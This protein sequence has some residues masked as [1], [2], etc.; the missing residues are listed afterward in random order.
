[1]QKPAGE[2]AP[3]PMRRSLIWSI[4]ERYLSA[5][6]ALAV[7]MIIARLLTP[8]QIGIFS[9]C[10]ATMLLASVLRDFGVTEYVLQERELTPAKLRSVMTVALATAWGVGALVFFSR[11][12]LAA[13]YDEPRLVAV[14]G[15]LS[16]NFLLLPF[17][18]PAFAMLSRQLRLRTVFAVQFATGVAGGLTSVALA[19]AGQ[20]ELSLAWGSVAGVATQLVL[21]LA[22]CRGQALTLPGAAHLREVL[23][24]GAYTM[25]SRALDVTSAN[26]HEFIIARHFGFTAV[27]LFSRAKGAVDLFQTNV[28]SA[29][30]RVASPTMAAAHRSDQSIVQM[31]AQGTANYTAL[32]WPAYL[33]LAAVA[34]ELIL[35]LFGPQWGPAGELAR[36][37]ALAMMPM[38]LSPLAGAAMAATGRVK[39]RLVV[40][41]VYTPVHLVALLALA[42]FGLQAMVWAWAVTHS[43]VAVAYATQLRAVLRCRV[44]ELYGP[45]LRSV[46]VALVCAAGL[47]AWLQV[48][49]RWGRAPVFVVGSTLLVTAGVWLSAVFITRHP[50]REQ[51]GW[52]LAR[53]RQGRA[54]RHPGD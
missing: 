14:L 15:V 53:L 22:I 39:R 23:R 51:V 2:A 26:V 43:V 28:A 36:W 25:S 46:A 7:S 17:A 21:V 47:L 45:T 19:L 30:V 40:S 27:G 10:A 12:A 29:L 50:M 31:F 44:A 4:A 34:P 49:P 18:S 8:L 37:L 32:A 24:F 16:I 1:M 20:G 41:L 54:R 11:D 5:V 13:Y 9:M 6:F 48:M 33:L 52:L 42:G 35:L 38:A 3:A